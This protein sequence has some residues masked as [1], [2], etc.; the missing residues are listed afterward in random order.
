MSNIKQE[1]FHN[2]SLNIDVIISVHNLIYLCL[3][4]DEAAHK[5]HNF[6]CLFH[7]KP[8]SSICFISDLWYNFAWDFLFNNVILTEF[9]LLFH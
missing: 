6:V 4:T 5:P 7:P 9:N 1:Y 3:M 8:I 2:G